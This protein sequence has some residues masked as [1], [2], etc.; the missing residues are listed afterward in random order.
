VTCLSASKVPGSEVFT[1]SRAFYNKWVGIV[2][3][4]VLV[5]VC[6]SYQLNPYGED[7][8]LFELSPTTKTYTMTCHGGP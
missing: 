4:I 8:V 5:P 7:V 2:E 1:Y 3:N 6:Y